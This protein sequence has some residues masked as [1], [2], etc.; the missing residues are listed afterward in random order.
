MVNILEKGGSD[1]I[2]WRLVAH[3]FDER[4]D[5]PPQTGILSLEQFGDGEK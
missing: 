2:D 4:V 5:E 3:L 1:N